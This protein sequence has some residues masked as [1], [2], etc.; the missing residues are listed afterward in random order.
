[1]NLSTK[2]KANF[3]CKFSKNHGRINNSIKHQI[4]ENNFSNDSNYS[5]STK[6]ESYVKNYDHNFQIKFWIQ[7]L[8]EFFKSFLYVINQALVFSERKKQF[9][10]FTNHGILKRLQNRKADSKENFWKWPSKKSRILVATPGE[11]KA[12][13]RSPDFLW[14]I[15]R[16]S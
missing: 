12:F 13:L 5:D 11:T 3:N 4:P 15:G 9:P 6:I 14:L 7:F 8:D 1:M 2:A 10:K 16:K